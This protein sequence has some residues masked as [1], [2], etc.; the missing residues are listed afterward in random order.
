MTNLLIQI[1]LTRGLDFH[2]SHFFQNYSV[3][4]KIRQTE[5]NHNYFFFFLLF[6]IAV[7]FL[8]IKLIVN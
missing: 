6:T 4:S 7:I 3:C 8:I 5:L 1:Y 2:S